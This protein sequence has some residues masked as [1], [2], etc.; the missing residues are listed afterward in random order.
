MNG[1]YLLPLDSDDIL[2]DNCVERIQQ[3][4]EQTGADVVA[5]SF[6]MFGTQQADIILMDNPTI[7][8]F[9]SAN[10]IGYC[11]AVKREVLQEVGG[12]SP[13]MFWGYEDFALWID[14]L[15]RGKT[16]VT[17]PE[18]LWLYRTKEQSMLTESLK[19]HE[20]LINRIIF[21]NPTVYV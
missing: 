13:R 1:D 9:K 18:K 6:R 7:N 21:D 11:S 4:I 20:E 5:P 10:R 2:L 8:D 12:Y 19:H 16:M 17:I 15:K 14:L 3:V